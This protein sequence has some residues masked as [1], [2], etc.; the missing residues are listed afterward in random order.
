MNKH[1]VL[2]SW[3]IA[4]VASILIGIG[5]N[6]LVGIGLFLFFVVTLSASLIISANVTTFIV[7]AI[8]DQ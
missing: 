7:K 2:F 5:T 4:L 6:A 3:A 1:Q 8:R